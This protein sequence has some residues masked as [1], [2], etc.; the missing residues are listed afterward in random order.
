M[1]AIATGAIT[2]ELR[3]HGRQRRQLDQHR[4][5]AAARGDSQ[6]MAFRLMKNE[7][8]TTATAIRIVL[9]LIASRIVPPDH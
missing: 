4:R 3:G 8:A 5:V 9:R 2:K 7:T 6:S 1:S